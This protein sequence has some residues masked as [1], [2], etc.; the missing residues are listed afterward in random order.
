MTRHPAAGSRAATQVALQQ[1][2]CMA[3]QA[4]NTKEDVMTKPTALRNRSA[5]TKVTEAEY[6]Q[7]Q[8]LADSTCQS[9]SEWIRARLLPQADKSRTEVLLAEVL[10]L[11][12]IS[13]NLLFAISRGEIKTQQEMQALIDQ[14]DAGKVARAARLLASCQDGAST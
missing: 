7:L 4:T 6:A 10:A 8:S 5:T 14:A 9:L 3:R 11:R 1:P 13:V 12:A 2:H